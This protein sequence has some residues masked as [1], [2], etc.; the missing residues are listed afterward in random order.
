MLGADL[1]IEHGDDVAHVA[2][3]VAHDRGTTYV[4]DRNAEPREALRRLRPEPLCRTRL[5]A[6]LPESISA[7]WLD[8]TKRLKGD[9]T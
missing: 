5:L 9:S 1:L 7:S 6:L 4:L 8:R 3:R 2:Q